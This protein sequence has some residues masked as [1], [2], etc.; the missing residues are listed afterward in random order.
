MQVDIHNFG[1]RLNIEG[2]ICQLSNL[3]SRKVYNYFIKTFQEEYNLQ[4]R[5]GYNQYNYDK[6]EIKDIFLRPRSAVICCKHREF[7]FK[8]LHGALYILKI[9]SINL[10]L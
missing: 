8:L 1:I 10:D 2:Q 4:V 7:Q 3:K 5:D 9:T 6:E